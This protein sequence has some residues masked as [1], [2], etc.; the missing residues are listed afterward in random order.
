MELERFDFMGI[1]LVGVR[2][3]Y[4]G[5][6]FEREASAYPRLSKS[7]RTSGWHVFRVENKLQNGIPD[8]V[9]FRGPLSSPTSAGKRT[10]SMRCLLYNNTILYIA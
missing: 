3:T 2:F 8:I 4:K 1:P 9:M 5:K 10:L 7:A 6:P